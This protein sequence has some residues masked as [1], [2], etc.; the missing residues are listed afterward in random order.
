MLALYRRLL[1]VRRGSP[2]LH[3]GALELLDCPTNVLGYAR[4][5]NDDDRVVLLNFDAVDVAVPLG[6]AY[7]IEVASNDI[8]LRGAYPGVVP[9]ETALVLRPA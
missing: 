5:G 7:E 4:R 3:G 9:A 6:T 1:D 2:A 8:R